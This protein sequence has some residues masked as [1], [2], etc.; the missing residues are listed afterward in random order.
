MDK[1]K[2]RAILSAN[3]KEKMMCVLIRNQAVFEVAREELTLEHFNEA[4]V[5]YQIAWSICL[6]H[7]EAHGELPERDMMMSEVQSVIDLDEDVMSSAEVSEAEAWL[8]LAYDEGLKPPFDD[9]KY[10]PW[11][12][13]KLK[14]FLEERVARTIQRQVAT[15]DRVVEDLPGLISQVQAESERISQI[16]E[17][18]SPEM[19]P[20]EWDLQGGIQAYGTGLGFFDEFLG[21]V[22]QAGGECYGLL[23]PFGSCKTTISVMLA[24]EM[25]RYAQQLETSPDWD[26]IRRL[27]FLVSYEARLENELRIR[28]LSYAASIDRARLESMGPKGLKGLSTSKTLQGYE[29]KMFAGK[30]AKGDT[31]FGEQGRAKKQMKV[32]NKHLRVLDMTGYDKSCPG[33][34][35]GY[36]AE[37]SRRISWELRKIDGPAKPLIVIVDYVGAMCRRHQAF[38]GKDDGHLRHLVTGAPLHFRNLVANEFDTPVWLPHQLSGKANEKGPGALLDHTDSAESKSYAENLDFNFCV[39]KLNPEGLC[40][41]TC[42]KHRR[43]P[44]KNAIVLKLRGDVCRVFQSE[45]HVIDR[46]KG[47]IVAKEDMNTVANHEAAVDAVGTHAH[48]NVDDDDEFYTEDHG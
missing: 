19:F 34:G 40:Q 29:K 10:I 21:G 14:R 3:D 20:D 45:K 26:G 39:G 44:A 38:L 1:V 12:T 6:D 42:S 7:F 18:T 23:G 16:G 37:I 47:L 9:K 15:D 41:L 5:M 32:M 31:V 43:A 4:E 27:A 48:T 2:R 35:N 36:V 30:L 33:A 17:G 11:G 28:S 25:C 24:V 13:K 46:Q 22:G 8:D